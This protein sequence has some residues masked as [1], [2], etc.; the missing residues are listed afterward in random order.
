MNLLAFIL[1][2]FFPG[3]GQVL[4]SRYLK[5]LFIFFSI[6]ILVDLSSVI[7]P[8]IWGW[9]DSAQA[10]T[11]AGILAAVIYLYNLW[12]IFNIVYYRKRKSLQRKRGELLKAGIKY[13]LQ[14]DLY[15]A[16]KELKKALKLDK[17]DIDVLYYLF[18]IEGSLGETARE[19]RLLNK[20]SLLDFDKKWVQ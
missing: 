17:D 2:L 6:I 12:D 3:L 15:G 5:G 8:L 11:F 1:S 10:R 13:Y 19:K 16:R 18:R 14:N 20:L 7:L 4:L 9:Q